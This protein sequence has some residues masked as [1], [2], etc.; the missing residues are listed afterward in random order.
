MSSGTEQRKLAAIM[1]TYMVGYSALAQRDEALALELLAESQ[2][3]LRA[4]FLLFDGREVKTTGDGFLVEFPSALQASQC[5][6]EI[7]RA[8][9][10]RNSTQPL[11]RHFHVR[12]GIHIGDVVHRE[13]DMYGDGV[14]IAARI[15]PLAIGGGICLSDAVYGQV[16]NKL[17][18]Q[19]TKLDG[20]ALKNIQLPV[21]VYRVVLP[22]QQQ[23]PVAAKLGAPSRSKPGARVFALGLLATV[24][25]IAAGWRFVQQSGKATRQ[26]AGSPG[27]TNSPAAT[28]AGTTDQ[29]SIAVLPF[30]N[31]S[32]DKA[33]EYLSD[34]MT[35]ELLNVLAQVPG[36]RV[37]GRSSSFAFK[38]RTEDNIFRKVGEQLHVTTVLEGSVRKAG[39][40]LRITAQLINVADGFQL[41][42]D[43][44]DRDMTNI[45]AIQSDIAARVAEALKVQ[46]LGAVAPQKKPTENLEAYKLY[47]QG[48]QL[49]N[50]R[51]IESVQQAVEYF[52]QAIGK[53]P[54]YAL[55]YAGLADCYVVLPNY[56]GLPPREAAPKARAAALKAL[57]LD[58]SLAEPHAALASFKA[59]FDWDWQGAEAGFRRAIALNPNYATGHQWL[60]VFV[61][62]PLGRFDEALG[63]LQKA[64]ELDPLSP[65]FNVDVAEFLGVVGQP[66]LGIRVLQKQI[67]IDPSLL[68]ARGILGAVYYS[69]GNLPEAVTQLETMRRL[70]GGGAYRLDY[71]GFIYA[72]A[73]RTNEARTLLGQ[74]QELQRL[75]FDHRV[76]IAQ[77]QHGL[78]DDEGALASLELA[79][80]EKAALMLPFNYR[81][82][83]KDL[84]PHP[85]A[86]AILKRM[87]LVK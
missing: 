86:Q 54:G 68:V 20:P 30:V 39:D 13:A 72:R 48:R 59:S 71:L 17:D 56:A 66:D 78:G 1:F 22:W 74:L 43:T 29:K 3:L 5:A 32:A 15:E 52:N 53:D 6:V 38:G 11:D 44:Y 64:Q 41:W 82:W 34:G 2:R 49:W 45:F 70:D 35:E 57:E 84:R 37:P 4:Q 9:V 87:N 51:T 50:R 21:E 18:A 36:L 63:E 24:V 12:I 26:G 7:Q 80:D 46:L 23:S 40:K 81:A 28:T 65:I 16:R 19:M 79:L 8:L 76:G 60:A 61:L 42:S 25:L 58:S 55:A 10:A 85:R 77:I 14:N 83:W 62:G 69:V 67:A 47:L 27:A 75:G 31:M 73:G 33:D